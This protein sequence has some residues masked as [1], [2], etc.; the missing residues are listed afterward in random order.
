VI[1]SAVFDSGEEENT[2]QISLRHAGTGDLRTVDTGWSWSLFI[3]SGFLGLPLFFRGLALWGTVMMV[4]W[5]LSLV[6]L[7]VTRPDTGLHMVD[8]G[9]TIVSLALCAFLGLKG[10][11]LTAKRYISLGYEFVDPDG[12]EARFAAQ[13]WDL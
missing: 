13:S 6:P 8:W 10:N 12:A 4:T 1:P 11:A 9:L 7:V 3:A 2:M 5:S